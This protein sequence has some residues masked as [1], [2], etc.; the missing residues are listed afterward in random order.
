MVDF[1]QHQR[2]LGMVPPVLCDWHRRDKRALAATSDARRSEPADRV[3]AG[4]HA[5]GQPAALHDEHPI[6]RV[7]VRQRQERRRDGVRRLDDERLA[8]LRRAISAAPGGH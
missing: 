2:I 1:A 4:D 7:I 8:G 5:C 3:I 6:D